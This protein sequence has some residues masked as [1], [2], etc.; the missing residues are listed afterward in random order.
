[1]HAENILD[2]RVVGRVVRLAQL[3][4]RAH[5]VV[6]FL[7]MFP[8]EIGLHF[9]TGLT[10]SVT[11]VDHRSRPSTGFP[12]I[13]IGR[14]TVALGPFARDAQIDAIIHDGDIDHAFIAAVGVIAPIG[15]E[16]G[17]ELIGRLCRNDVHDASGCIAAI[18][19]ALRATQHFDLIDV[20]EF[21][22]EEMVADER[23]IVQRH[24]HGRIGRH[25]NRLRADAANLDGVA[26]EIRFG[27]GKV[28]HFLHQIRAAGDL[29]RGELFL[30]QRRNRNRNGL[31]IALDL[32]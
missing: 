21:L 31:N 4:G 13:L 3:L 24:R 15:G 26:A 7:E 12:V 11:R 18:E 23:D 14:V 9:A 20:E 27:E 16:H 2:A 6:A 10:P 19:R 8:D 32:R 22:L 28:R 17:L 1:M 5:A 25:R 29:A 30:R